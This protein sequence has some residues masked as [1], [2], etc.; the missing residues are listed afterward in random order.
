MGG[1]YR[2]K[3]GYY[4]GEKNPFVHV[5]HNIGTNSVA[6]TKVG[7]SLFTLLEEEED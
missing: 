2:K 5:Q 4:R 3:T 7:D 6:D 1:R